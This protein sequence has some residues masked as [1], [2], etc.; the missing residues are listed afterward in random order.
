MPERDPI[1]DRRDHLVDTFTISDPVERDLD[2][3]DLDL[4]ELDR[5]FEKGSEMWERYAR[6]PH[7]RERELHRRAA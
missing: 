2:E 5:A 4:S 7:P 6:Q 1:A 3:I